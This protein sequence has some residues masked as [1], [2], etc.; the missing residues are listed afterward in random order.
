MVVV[1]YYRDHV[2]YSY[3]VVPH[4]S[5]GSVQLG[6]Y[7]YQMKTLKL[8][9][10]T[11]PKNYYYNLL[12]NPDCPYRLAWSW[13]TYVRKQPVGYHIVYKQ[14]WSDFLGHII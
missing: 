7:V 1:L 12:P 3:I 2:M 4:Y 10:I 11:K 8:L 9:E 6:K 5:V 14:T 13:T